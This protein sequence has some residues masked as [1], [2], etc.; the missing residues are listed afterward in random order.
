MTQTMI[1]EIRTARLLLRK[2]APADAEK[3]A[4]MIGQWEV[5][6]WLTQPPYP[7]KIDDAEAFIAE[8]ARRRWFYLIEAHDVVGAVE[9]GDHLGY[10]LGAA[11]WGKG[12][13]TEATR[14]LLTEYFAET[15][16]DHLLSGYLQGNIASCNTLSK[17]GFLETGRR[18]VHC[19]PRNAEAVHIDMRLDRAAFLGT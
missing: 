12:Y 11:H 2:P 16:A 3:I 9:I 10:W 8:A 4:G 5:I 19:R 17:L 15:G 18:K 14:A 13:M 6:R 1:D 7:Y